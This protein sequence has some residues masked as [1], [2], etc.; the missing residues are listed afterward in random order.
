MIALVVVAVAALCSQQALCAPPMQQ[1]S[2]TDVEVCMVETGTTYGESQNFAEWV[3]LA[4]TR[5]RPIASVYL[6]RRCIC[7]KD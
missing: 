1:D 3:C 2:K 7:V 4:C 5:C 6:E